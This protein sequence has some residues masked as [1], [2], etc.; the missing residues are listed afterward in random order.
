M[1]DKW[2]NYALKSGKVQSSY[3]REYCNRKK[4]R[5]AGEAGDSNSHVESRE[6]QPEVQEEVRFI[7]KPDPSWDK[8]PVNFVI[9]RPDDYIQETDTFILNDAW[10]VDLRSAEGVSMEEVNNACVEDTEKKPRKRRKKS[11][12]HL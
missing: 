1:K 12:K 3:Q 11:I 9:R 8:D 10:V 5:K 7:V 6:V 2:S 4:F